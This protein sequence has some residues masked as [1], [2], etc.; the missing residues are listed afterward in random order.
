MGRGSCQAEV[1]CVGKLVIARGPGLAKDCIFNGSHR[2]DSVDR[3]KTLDMTA[4]SASGTD[5]VFCCN[6]HYLSRKSQ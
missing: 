3:A 5:T 6:H 1:R 4:R 2:R